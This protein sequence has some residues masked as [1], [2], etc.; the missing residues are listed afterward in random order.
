MI[1]DHQAYLICVSHARAPACTFQRTHSTYRSRHSTNPSKIRPLHSFVLLVWILP[2]YRANLKHHNHFLTPRLFMKKKFKKFYVLLASLSLVR[3]AVLY[4]ATKQLIN[5]TTPTE[6]NPT[7][8]RIDEQGK[9]VTVTTVAEQEKKSSSNEPPATVIRSD[10]NNV[11]EEN[12]NRP[13]PPAASSTSFC[14]SPEGSLHQIALD[15]FQ[16]SSPLGSPSH[17]KLKTVLHAQLYFY[18]DLR[19]GGAIVNLNQRNMAKMF[20]MNQRNMAKM[21]E[22]YGLT[23]LEQRPPKDWT[24][25]TLVETPIMD[26]VCP[27]KEVDCRNRTRILIQ[28]E[29]YF[30]DSVR[31]CHESPNC[32]V[33]EFSDLNYRSAKERGWGDSFVL[34]PVMTQFPSRLAIQQQSDDDFEIIKPLKERLYDIVFFGGVWTKRRKKY[35]NPTDYLANHPNRTV[36]IKK[37]KNMKRQI[38]AYKEAKVCLVVHTHRDD[39]GGEY[40]RLSEF[41][42]FGCIPVLEQFGDKIGIERY[43]ECGRIVFAKGPDLMEAVANVTAKIDEGWYQDFSHA[44]WWKAGIQWETLLSSAFSS[45]GK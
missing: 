44:N 7:T 3:L 41:A 20:K 25:V 31:Q 14:S 34:L 6:D 32:I 33:L 15:M 21:L 8:D 24:N 19:G 27:L 11:N 42:P 36:I 17:N 12:I 35:A 2:R 29:Q 23:R 10:D 18:I 26:T 40:H 22:G 30:K 1:I 28:T 39:S 13:P 43:T 9:E 4:S 38:A 5:A 37:D 45:S 16:H